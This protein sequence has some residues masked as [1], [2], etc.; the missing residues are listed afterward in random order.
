MAVK[1]SK[2]GFKP[3][4]AK[5]KK[6]G[7][8]VLEDNARESKRAEKSAIEWPLGREDVNEGTLTAG[9]AVGYAGQL[10][11]ITEN[12]PGG[13]CVVALDEVLT[14]LYA[15][16][17]FYKI[18]GYSPE[19]FWEKLDGK[20]AKTIWPPDLPRV[21]RTIEEALAGGKECFESEHRILHQDGTVQ[22]SLVRGAFSKMEQEQWAYCITVDITER[23]SMEEAL[24]VNEERFRIA[25]AQTDSTI[26]DYDIR[27]KRMLHGDKSAEK[28]GLTKWTENV[29]ESLVKDGFVHPD[30]AG[31]FLEMYRKICAGAPNASCTIQARLV[32]GEYAWQRVSMTNV[33]D[34]EGN[35]L[36]A[37]GFLEDIDVQKRREEALRERS[38]R[39]ALTGLYNKG[40]TEMRI[41]EHLESGVCGVN[42]LFIVD[43]DEFKIVNDR[44]GHLFGDR[45]LAESARRISKLF[46]AED[47]IGRIG[48]DEF[49]VFMKGVQDP[50]IV[51][52]RAGEICRA[53]SYA[54]ESGCDIAKVSCSIGIAGS[55]RDGR[56]FDMLYQ[57]ADIALYAAKKRG[58]NC[59]CLFTPDME[60]DAGWI[61]Y[62][63]SI[64]DGQG[65]GEDG[66]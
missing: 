57:K 56:T 12:I 33:Y 50:A 8:N 30:S 13:V 47:I 18:Y 6:Q 61:P 51:E 10:A 54:F 31:V 5:A 15:N 49:I 63:S 43:I 20:V 21:R 37:V 17:F 34:G 4:K 64:I 48:G 3:V 27:E 62:S 38:E 41:S 25:L 60:I 59:Y 39:D 36:R 28:Y 46:H 32:T 44:H 65:M 1:D 58:K 7:E 2:M 52:R 11:E 42:A 19:Q 16:R 40:T 55:P 14:L 29:P 45:T 66:H 22:W 24:R 35:A 23:K 53:F 9:K 26:F